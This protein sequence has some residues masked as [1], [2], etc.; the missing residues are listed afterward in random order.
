M[1]A[2][3]KIAH[4]LGLFFINGLEQEERIQQL[5]KQ[6][7]ALGQRLHDAEGDRRERTGAVP[8]EDSN[9]GS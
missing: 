9:R 8:A 2:R 7:Q 5:E 3:D 4:Q 6:V 1:T